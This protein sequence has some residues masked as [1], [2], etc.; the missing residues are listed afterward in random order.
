MLMNS[1]T[2]NKE[3]QRQAASRI[4]GQ[5]QLAFVYYAGARNSEFHRERNMKNCFN[6]NVFPA[7]LGS[8]PLATIEIARSFWA[9]KIFKGC[10][11]RRKSVDSECFFNRPNSLRRL[12]NIT[13]FRLICLEKANAKSCLCWKIKF[14]VTTFAN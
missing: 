4:H 8:S 5:V 1:K 6:E 13:N 14:W 12:L 2:T 7:S 3:R 11:S 9:C 10:G